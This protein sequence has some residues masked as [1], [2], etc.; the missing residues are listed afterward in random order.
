MDAA[1]EPNLTAT[2][3]QLSV[4]RRFCVRSRCRVRAPS[5]VRVRVTVVDVFY[6]PIMLWRGAISFPGVVSGFKVAFAFALALTS[7]SFSI[8]HWSCSCLWAHVWFHIHA[9]SQTHHFRK[10]CVATITVRTLLDYGVRT[11]SEPSNLW[12]ITFH[13]H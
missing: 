2:F 8:S 13:N 9:G 7:F 4:S 6:F 3:V 10:L 11:N 1:Q 12:S 5:P